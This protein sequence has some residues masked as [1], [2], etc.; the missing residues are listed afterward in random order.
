VEKTVFTLIVAVTFA[1]GEPHVEHKEFPSLYECQQE[2][3]RYVGPDVKESN[4]V[5]L[6][7]EAS[8]ER[9]PDVGDIIA[10][11]IRGARKGRDNLR[12]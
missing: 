11:C 9:L 6:R 4:L 1:W 5:V 8:I 3:R 2:Q 10:V 12:F 7:R